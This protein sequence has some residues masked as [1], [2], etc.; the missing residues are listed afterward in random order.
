[1]VDEVM[2]TGM[3]FTLHGYGVPFQNH[4]VRAVDDITQPFDA[5]TNIGTVT[6]AGDGSFTFTDPNPSNLTTRFYRV[7]YP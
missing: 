3:S 6:A 1:V 4:T 2:R 5:G 7:V